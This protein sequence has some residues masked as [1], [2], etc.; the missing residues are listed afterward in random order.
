MNKFCQTIHMTG[1]QAEIERDPKRKQVLGAAF[2]AFTRY[3]FR[4]TSMADIAD[5]AGMSRPLLYTMFR[6]K[7]DIF[8]SLSLLYF[9]EAATGV[10]Q[11]LAQP[12]PVAEVLHHGLAAYSGKIG[13]VLLSAPHGA[14][15]LEIGHR[16][17]D[18]IVT[19][20][21]ARVAALFAAYFRSQSEAGTLRLTTSPEETAA[22]LLGA[23]EGI[24]AP[25][26]E[27]YRSRLEHLAQMFARGLA[28]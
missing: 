28:A 14:E 15:M 22:L 25:P 18:D 9:D 5:A 23:A 17:C 1:I 27:V 13:E 10:E 16:I 3:G 4:R 7:E 6:N 26:Y 8:R 2:E 21:K 19:D 24:K 11:A 20:G 12:G